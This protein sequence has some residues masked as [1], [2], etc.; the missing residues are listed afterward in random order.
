[1]RRVVVVAGRDV[2]TAARV[3]IM[4]NAGAG[5]TTLAKRLA[6]PGGALHLD[7]VFFEGAPA[8]GCTRAD[9]DQLRML[10]A[11]LR[12]RHARGWVVEGVFA[13]LLEA[14]IPHAD[15]LVWLDVDAPTCLA[16][17]QRRGLGSEESSAA[18]EALT[19]WAA[20]YHARGAADLCSRAAHA[21]VA[22]CA[23]AAAVPVVCVNDAQLVRLATDGGE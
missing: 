13:P 3:C 21:R 19:R 4:G 15:L 18:I 7:A 9:E 10:H 1:M 2:H 23:V 17:I 8:A 22:A 6:P 11:F 14:C 16:N 12:E 20:G 5:K